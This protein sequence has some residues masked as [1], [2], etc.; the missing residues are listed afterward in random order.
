MCFPEDYIGNGSVCSAD[1]FS[2]GNKKL[3]LKL[4]N[5]Q[6]CLGGMSEFYPQQIFTHSQILQSGRTLC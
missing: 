2:M 5:V 6:H 3:V 1:A 4:I